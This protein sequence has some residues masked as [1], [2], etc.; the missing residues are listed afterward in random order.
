[1]ESGDGSK[2]HG[3]VGVALRD[4]KGHQL[5]GRRLQ[6]MVVMAPHRGELGSWRGRE[7]RD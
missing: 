6:R 4:I 7:G 2:G 1:M 5:S 3:R